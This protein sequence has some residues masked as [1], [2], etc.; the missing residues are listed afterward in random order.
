MPM[1]K[2]KITHPDRIVDRSMGT[3]KMDIVHYY[4]RVASLMMPHLKARPV[5]LL[6]APEGVKGQMFFQKHMDTTKMTGVRA[7]PTR[8]D[9]DHEPL[10][11]VATEQGLAAAAQM[12]VLEFHTWNAV[13]SLIA[14]PDRMTFDLDPGKGVDW[15]SMQEAAMLLQV[16]LQ[17][18][19]LEPWVKTSGGK[20]LH[21]IVPLKRRHDWDTVK[22][23]SQ[24]V[25]LHLAKTFPKRFASKSGPRNRI[26]K[27]F[28]DY[29]RNGWGATT[30]STWSLRARPGM[31]V[32]VPIAWK[33]VEQ[34][35]SATHWNID[36]IHER[37]D[38]GNQ[39]WEHYSTSAATLTQ[40]RKI[41]K[42]K[43]E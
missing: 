23:T 42:R 34:L 43:R 6:R 28:I 31:G 38:I 32:S 35:T 30:V 16:F 7:L 37:L 14:K 15:V 3:T 20:G 41:L 40:A 26:G 5:S 4:A 19:K 11:E 12:N 18:L 25:V 22:D 1:S 33:E 27:I 10:L 13:K 24:A 2:L 21:V 29:L 36:N 8:L 17:E 39:P 9:P